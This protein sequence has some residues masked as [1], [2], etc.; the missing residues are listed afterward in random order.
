MISNYDA[1]R[2]RRLES[3][4]EKSA[5][6]GEPVISAGLR[7]FY[8]VKGPSMEHGEKSVDKIPPDQLR[9]E[10]RQSK[11]SKVN[12]HAKPSGE[13]HPQLR[14]RGARISGENRR[15]HD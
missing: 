2:H 13:R 5:L 15:H 14:L 9:Y 1:D 6:A 11:V 10:Q 12:R 3:R 8:H 7:R 4:V